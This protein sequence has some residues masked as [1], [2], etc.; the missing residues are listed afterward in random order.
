MMRRFELLDRVVE[1]PGV[2]GEDDDCDGA[3]DN[4]IPTAVA[5]VTGNVWV[6]S[7]VLLD[8]WG[9]SHP[10]GAE[11]SYAWQLISMPPTTELTFEAIEPWDEVEASFTPDVTGVYVAEVEVW[12]GNSESDFDSVILNVIPRPSNSPP[13]VDLGPDLDEALTTSCYFDSYGNPIC[14][15]PCSFEFELDASGAVDADYDPLEISW[16][17]LSGTGTLSADIGDTTVLTLSLSP[18]A[19]GVPVNETVEVGVTVVDCVGA[20]TTDEVMITAECVGE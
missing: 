5:A 16:E 3:V 20:V 12:S 10:Q 6:C 19:I 13:T 8:G 1:H 9:S 15:P 18:T 2:V 4:P 11:L 17:I 14:S 7:P